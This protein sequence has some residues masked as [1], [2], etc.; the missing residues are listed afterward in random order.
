MAFNG[1]IK[2][3]SFVKRKVSP[4]LVGGDSGV[5]SIRPELM[6]EGSRTMKGRGINDLA[7]ILDLS[8]SP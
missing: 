3:D 7:K 6:A 5:S 2:F 8:P 4:P 1:I